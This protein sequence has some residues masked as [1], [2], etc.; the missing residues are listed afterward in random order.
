M[1][2]LK[3]GLTAML[4]A[5]ALV[6]YVGAGTASAA[7]LYKDINWW[8][9]ETQGTGVR[10]NATLESGT[11]AVFENAGG[12][13]L[14]T[15]TGSE[16]EFL[17]EKAGENGSTYVN[18]TGSFQNHTYTG[19]KNVHVLRFG[20]WEIRNVKGTN[21]GLVI[22]TGT[23]VTVNTAAGSCVISTNQ[24]YIG[25]LTGANEEKASATLDVNGALNGTGPFG[26]PTT[27]RWTA[28]YTVTNLN[29]LY[30]YP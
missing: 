19:C 26:C 14:E 25:T 15:C 28:S 22:S 6:A 24:T 12:T 13:P 30:V 23:E 5:V 4:A 27:A 29:G 16:M 11:S 10:F 8:P 17:I 20:T 3:I 9:D 18:P 21:G 1:R 7:E 2:F